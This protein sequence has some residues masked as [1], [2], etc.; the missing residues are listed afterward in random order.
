M[1]TKHPRACQLAVGVA[2]VVL[3]VIVKLDLD[4]VV[5]VLVTVVLLEAVLVIAGGGGTTTASKAL[6]RSIPPHVSVALPAQGEL[7]SAV[8][9]VAALLAR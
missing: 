9:L 2:E 1:S 5:E 6:K 7:H 8:A 4:V 3:L